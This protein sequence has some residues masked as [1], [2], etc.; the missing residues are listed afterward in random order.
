LSSDHLFIDEVLPAGSG[1]DLLALTDGGLARRWRFVETEGKRRLVAGDLF[2]VSGGERLRRAQLGRI[3]RKKKT[4]HPLLVL[5]ENWLLHRW[6]ESLWSGQVPR[7]L[8]PIIGYYANASPR[9]GSWFLTGGG[10]KQVLSDYTGKAERLAKIDCPY[11]RYRIHHIIEAPGR[12]RVAVASNDGAVHVWDLADNALRYTENEVARAA[13]ATAFDASGERLA[14]ARVD[15]EGGNVHEFMPRDRHDRLVRTMETATSTLTLVDLQRGEALPPVT[16]DGYL[17]GIAWDPSGDA[18]IAVDQRARLIRL[19]GQ[20]GELLQ[21][22]E[23]GLPSVVV[24]DLLRDERLVAVTGPSGGTRIFDFDFMPVVTGPVPVAG[25]YRS[26]F[27]P[28]GELMVDLDEEGRLRIWE[29]TTGRELHR[30]TLRETA[31]DARGL[32]WRP[33]LSWDHRSGDI[34]LW[35]KGFKAY[36]L[37]ALGVDEDRYPRFLPQPPED[38]ADRKRTERLKELYP[39]RF[40]P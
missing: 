9:H 5:T 15:E 28:R 26:V 6:D 8:E 40:D 38:D 17:R 20:T 24:V 34:F 3:T 35:V 11:G 31:N 13:V 2:D 19:D 23:T 22:V 37:S 27:G 33:Q 29:T 10:S 21:M 7:G 32:A 1:S 30:E 25:L 4:T 16:F 18:V 36:R 14:I 12:Q 39:S